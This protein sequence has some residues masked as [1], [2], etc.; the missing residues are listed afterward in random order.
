MLLV[1]SAGTL[2]ASLILPPPRKPAQ[3]LPESESLISVPEFHFVDRSGRTVS[4]SDLLGKV[5][6][7]SFIFTRCEGTCLQV[8][9]TLHKLQQELNLSKKEQLRFVTFT[10]DPEFDTPEILQRYSQN[11]LHRAET[12]RWLFLTGPSE[13]IRSMM[14]NTFKLAFEQNPNPE[15]PPGRKYDHGTFIFL[16]DKNG[17]IRG[18]FEGL[19][20]ASDE[21]GER[22]RDSCQRLIQRVHDLLDE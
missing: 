12:E 16:V 17:L 10:M 15:T 8:T 3:T 11:P 19:Q 18:H 4:N 22:Y 20:G 2:V 7:A 1:V 6:I 9:A 5:W 14:K 13:Q 21:T